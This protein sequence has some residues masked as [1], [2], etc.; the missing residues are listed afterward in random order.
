[1]NPLFASAVSLASAASA[2][3]RHRP[4]ILESIETAAD[5]V[6]GRI[7][8]TVA[9]RAGAGAADHL[10]QCAMCRAEAIEATLALE[11]VRR[12]ADESA[13]MSETTTSSDAWPRLR[14]RLELSRRRAREAAWRARANVAGLIASTLI[15][16]VVVGPLTISGSSQGWTPAREPSGLSSRDRFVGSIERSYLSRTQS[17]LAVAT[18]ADER[19]APSIQRLLPD[20][21]RPSTKEVSPTETT[22]RTRD[23]S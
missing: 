5:V 1:M 15:V 21:V 22:G 17:V 6:P 7:Y 10:E 14:A 8:G 16:A 11:T 19:P 3:R 13:A 2:C 20:G 18:V 4:A 23:V 9:G 12:W